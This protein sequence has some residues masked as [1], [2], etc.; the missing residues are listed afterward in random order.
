M[1][2]TVQLIVEVDRTLHA[3]LARR[4]AILGV[5]IDVMV[6]RLVQNNV[7]LSACESS[8]AEKAAELATLEER[9][10]QHPGEPCPELLARRR[11]LEVGL[12]VNEDA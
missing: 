3:W 11:E 10:S 9:I 1:S 5:S 6:L 8:S 7:L 2:D 4:S 12:A